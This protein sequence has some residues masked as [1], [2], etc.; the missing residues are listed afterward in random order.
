M[1]SSGTVEEQKGSKAARDV[2]E[3][4]G[5]RTRFSWNESVWEEGI[6]HMRRHEGSM[7][8]VGVD[9]KGEGMCSEGD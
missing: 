1:I 6:R 9:E 2:R 8:V 7:R 3:S 4:S 5:E